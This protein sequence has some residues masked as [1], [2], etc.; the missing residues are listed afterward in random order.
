MLPVKVERNMA[1][2][3]ISILLFGFSRAVAAFPE[4]VEFYRMSG[5]VDYLLK[6]VVPDIAAY[7]AVYRPF[8]TLAD[9]HRRK[10]VAPKAGALP[11]CATPR[12][13]SREWGDSHDPVSD[14]ISVSETA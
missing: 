14:G 10:K 1:S 3:R 11:D 5:E 9:A 13:T 7:D 8:P 2:G 6:I 4:V 12:E